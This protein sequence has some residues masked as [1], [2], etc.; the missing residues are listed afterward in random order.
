MY[1]RFSLGIYRLFVKEVLWQI[2]HLVNW[3]YSFFEMDV[4]I[5]VG[6]L[7]GVR[8]F[9]WCQNLDVRFNFFFFVPGN[10][11]VR[12]WLMC[13]VTC[14]WALAVLAC[15]TNVP[16]TCSWALAVVPPYQLRVVRWA[17]AAFVSVTSITATDDTCGVLV[18]VC[19]GQNIISTRTTFFPSFGASTQLV[20]W[21]TD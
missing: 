13:L 18:W 10:Q 2:Y 8:C 1:D 14:S 6:W 12:V 21:T 9:V 7:F 20:Y 17:P 4:L 19:D 11:P 16:C 15:M 3:T 5:Y